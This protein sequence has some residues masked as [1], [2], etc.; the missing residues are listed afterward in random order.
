MQMNLLRVL[1]F[2]I[3]ELAYNSLTWVTA[4]PKLYL[5]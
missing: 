3:G 4:I 5:S 1:E 2:Q